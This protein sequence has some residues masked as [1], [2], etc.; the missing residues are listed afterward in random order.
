MCTHKCRE[1]GLRSS[2]S[3]KA[4]KILPSPFH[5]PDA[6]RACS[7]LNYLQSSLPS[8]WGPHLTQP[9]AAPTSLFEEERFFPSA[10]VFALL[11]NSHVTSP[12]SHINFLTLSPG[13]LRPSPPVPCF[14]LAPSAL[15][16]YALRA[17]LPN[18]AVLSGNFSPVS[19]KYSR[20]TLYFSC[21]GTASHHK[22]TCVNGDM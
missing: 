21:E 6:L 20:W 15:V 3:W 12:P 22:N 5:K 2:R 13:P 16:W 4:A 14:F 8:L 9:V 17:Q 18:P 1:V 19:D 10:M 11:D 7:C